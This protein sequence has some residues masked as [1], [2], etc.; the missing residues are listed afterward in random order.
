[1]KWEETDFSYTTLVTS[2]SGNTTTATRPSATSITSIHTVDATSIT[3]VPEAKGIGEST[4]TVA[5]ESTP[6]R[7]TRSPSA[8]RLCQLTGCSVYRR[9]TRFVKVCATRHIVIDA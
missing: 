6:A 3:I 8:R 2:N 1:M 7:C 4:L 5:S 9:T